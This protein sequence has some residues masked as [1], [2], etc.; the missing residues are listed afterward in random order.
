VGAVRV[1]VLFALPELRGGGF[2][3]SRPAD[4]VLVVIPGATISPAL[5]RVTGL[6]GK[7]AIDATNI[8]PERSE[9]WPR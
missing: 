5:A 2:R 3:L 1:V 9:A 6:K 4:V 7:I 8:L